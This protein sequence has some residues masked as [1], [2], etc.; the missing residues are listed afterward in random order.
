DLCIQCAQCSFIC[1]HATIRVKFYDPK[2]LEKAPEGFKSVDARSKK[3]AGM[4]YTVQ[5]APEDCTGCGEC[6]NICPGVKKVNGQKTGEKALMM[7]HQ[8][9]LR[10]KEARNWD[11]FL[12]IPDTDPTIMPRTTLIGSQLLPPTFEFSGACAGCGETPYVK[13]VSQLFGDRAI[14]AN[15]T[16]CSSI[17]G[18]NLPTTP[19]TTRKDGR[20]PSWSNS[21]FEDAAEFGFGMRLTSDK[22]A[23]HAREMLDRF[24][25]EEKEGLDKDL[26][27]AL[28]DAVQTTPEAIEEQR[29]R[30]S[31]LKKQLEKL[32]DRDAKLL[33]SLS[34][35]LIKRSIWIF[36]GDGW[37]YDIG[38][39]GLDHVL[40]SGKDI[41]ALVLDTE[42]YSNTGGQM[43][44]ATPMGAIAR[45]AEG[46]KPTPKKD[47][48]MMAMSY[49]NV[50]VARVA[51]GANMMQTVRAFNEAD[52]Y[53]GP[54]VIIAYSHCIAHGIDMSWGFE[55]QKK[56]VESGAWILYRY[57]PQ[58]AK[59]GKNPL[60]IDSKDPKIDVEDYM[61]SEIRF[62][63][64]KR[65]NPEAAE[66][67]LNLVR[68][69]IKNRLR[70]YKHLATLDYSKK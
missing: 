65:S 63:A 49:G 23:E 10:E 27:I 47:L 37:A 67:Y 29:K 36:G 68:E 64:L 32:N 20:G 18:G 16:G 11:F 57:N 14:I 2:Y 28:R 43:S 66:K 48:G 60:I 39:G 31:E 35:Y 56:A 26:M 4:K 41:N 9:P 40:A 59:E 21:L 42:V 7:K 6:A 3:F 15:A 61:Y 34:D 13:L 22:L 44:K 17:Y 5:V 55:Q 46:G 51:M 1:P 50:Y 69:D 52:A 19:Y 33:Y 30:V 62:R 45:F 58:L 38:Y 25:K 8:I 24:I 12:S 54:S 70:I 53:D